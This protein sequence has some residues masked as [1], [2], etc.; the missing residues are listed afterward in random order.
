MI[1]DLDSVAGSSPSPHRGGLGSS[2]LVWLT[3]VVIVGALLWGWYALQESGNRP[4]RATALLTEQTPTL[5]LDKP[6]VGQSYTLSVAQIR[7]CLREDIRIETV[8]SRVATTRETELFNAMVNGYN[9]R[10]TNFQYRDADLAQARRDIDAARAWIV[11]EAVAELAG[12]IARGPAE[13]PTSSDFSP[14][15]KDVQELLRKVGYAPGRPDG[16][17]GARTRAAIEAFERDQGKAPTGRVSESL[18]RDLADRALSLSR[19]TERRNADPRRFNAT[20]AELAAIGEICGGADFQNGVAGYN[21]CVESQLAE[22]AKLGGRPD[23]L[24]VTEAEM[25]AIDDTCGGTKLLNGPAAYY[26]CV[27]QQ[28]DA[29]QQLDSKP[30]FAGVSDGDREAIEDACAGTKF[31]NGPAAFYRCAE[32]RLA[33]LGD[34]AVRR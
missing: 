22:L 26:R 16:L 6:R 23:T 5:E 33:A 25:S 7:W 13:Q 18:R 8:R 14:L 28:I 27:A 2:A 1:D 10:C 31:F 17:Y 32:E 34:G 11:E 30:T 4:R 9:N 3:G 29:L 15:T 12:P 24:A 19:A 20:P 21:R